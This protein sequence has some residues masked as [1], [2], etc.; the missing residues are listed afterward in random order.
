MPTFEHVSRRDISPPEAVRALSELTAQHGEGLLAGADADLLA[1]ARALLAVARDAGVTIRAADA[2]RW[3]FAHHLRGEYPRAAEFFESADTAAPA[4]ERSRLFSA[5]ASTWWARGDASRAA[6]LAEAALVEA[7]EAGDEAA[8]ANAWVAQALVSAAEGDRAANVRAYEHALEHAQRAGDVLTEVRVRSNLGSM[9]LEEGRY[10]A[11]LH[12][13]DLAVEIADSA[14]VGIVGAL[15]YINRAEALTGLGRLDE[16]RAEI[17]LAERLF[18]SAESPLLDFAVLLEADI[19]RL[20]GSASRASA[21]YREVLEHSVSTGNAQLRSAALSGLAR[22]MI[23]ADASAARDYARRAVTEPAALGDVGALLA[24]GWVALAGGEGERAA[25]RAEEA[26]GEAGRRH[27]LPAL[28]DGLE[29][30]A[31]A[32][33]TMARSKD[34]D[35]DLAEAAEIWNE[36]GNRI[37]LAMNRLVRARLSG[38]HGAEEAGRR[39]LEGFGVRVDAFRIAGPLWVVGPPS[40]PTV[41]VRTLGSFELMIDGEP[42]PTSA[43]RSRKSRQIVMVLASRGGRRM[44]RDELCETLWPGETGTRARL[45]VGLSNARATLDPGRRHDPGRFLAADRDHVWLDPTEVAIDVAEFEALAEA[46]LRAATSGDGMAVVLLQAAAARYTGPFLADEAPADWMIEVRDRARAAAVSVKR[47]LALRLTSGD[48]PESAIG[49][50][51]SVLGDDPYDET[52]H[53]ELIRALAS[54]RRHGEARRARR[55]YFARMAELGVAPQHVPLAGPHAS[56]A[57]DRRRGPEG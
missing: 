48:D 27:D 53:L 22:T 57:V 21:A 54:A 31:I 55:V 19:H 32:R 45:S 15:A 18:R 8:L 34:I 4:D 35:S 51:V 24:D 43:W 56:D 14:R 7:R 26:A 13:L 11:A 10:L 49:W 3:G 12:E 6:P 38:D 33:W 42:V 20:R 50:W 36:T 25:L 16:A 2:W 28:A 44:S 47:A 17:E 9:H 23:A 5:Q 52:V 29:L 41:A 1:E 46:G 30:G 40:T 37:R 39:A